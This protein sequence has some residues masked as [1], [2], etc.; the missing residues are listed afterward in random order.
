MMAPLISYSIGDNSPVPEI[1][2]KTGS[3]PV[4]GV[5]DRIP[6]E[7]P[8]TTLHKM[9]SAMHTGIREYR[10]FMLFSLT[11]GSENQNK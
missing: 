11:Y 8:V 4:A 7:I 10:L 6:G 9:Q 5:F 1:T 2:G 3:V